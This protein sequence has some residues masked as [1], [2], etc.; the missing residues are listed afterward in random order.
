[1]MMGIGMPTILQDFLQWRPDPAFLFGLWTGLLISCI[2]VNV[3]ARVIWK[4][5]LQPSPSMAAR[6]LRKRVCAECGKR[7]PMARD[8]FR[9]GP[10]RYCSL[11]CRQRAGDGFTPAGPPAHPVD[12][13]QHDGPAWRW[14]CAGCERLATG[15]PG[16]KRGNCWYCAACA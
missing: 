8:Q 7:L 10:V 9:S 15:D 12:V 4:Y 11:T 16:A 6:M 5:G 2:I 1:M 3:T 14:V 13:Q